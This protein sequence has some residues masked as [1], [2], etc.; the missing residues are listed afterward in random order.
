VL[1][2]IPD[3]HTKTETPINTVVK[4]VTTKVICLYPKC[5]SINKI[6]G[7]IKNDLVIIFREM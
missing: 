2:N 1:F 3:G 5:K 7:F 6:T 4:S